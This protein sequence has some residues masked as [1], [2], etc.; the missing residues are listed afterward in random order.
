M[1]TLP[2]FKMIL[3]KQTFQESNTIF[4]ILTMIPFIVSPI[5]TMIMITITIIL[6]IGIFIYAIYLFRQKQLSKIFKQQPT[7]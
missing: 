7:K 1:F 4:E 3:V 6:S 5:S 2:Q